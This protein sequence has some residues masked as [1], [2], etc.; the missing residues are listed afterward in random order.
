[1]KSSTFW[2]DYKFFTVLVWLVATTG[3]VFVLTFGK[4]RTFLFLNT[5]LAPQ[6][7]LFFKYWTHLGEAIVYAGGLML[8][9]FI[10]FRLVATI[11]VAGIL[12]L[13]SVGLLKH[14]IF[15]E[16]QRPTAYF[17]NSEVDLNEVSGTAVHYEPS[18]PSGHTISAFAFWGVWALFLRKKVY[19]LGFFGVAFLVGYSRIHLSFHFLEDVAAGMLVGWLIATLSYIWVR[20]WPVSWLDRGLIKR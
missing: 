18:F 17:A 6:A 5:L 14:V 3:I 13:S 11:A 1:M 9:L 8:A 16:Y 4:E 19:Q 2:R 7:D 10:R 12:T 15:D 20:N